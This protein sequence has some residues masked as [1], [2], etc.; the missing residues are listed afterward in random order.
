MDR[1][2][3]RGTV[4]NGRGGPDGEECR[5]N[6]T[7]KVLEDAYCS[8]LDILAEGHGEQEGEGRKGG[9]IEKR[10]KISLGSRSR[11]EPAEQKR[12]CLP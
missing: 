10:V 12:I 5:Q 4:S 3:Y 9:E 11:F 8:R 7:A 2:T 6:S 1:E